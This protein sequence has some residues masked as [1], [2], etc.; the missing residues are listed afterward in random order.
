MPNANQTLGLYTFGTGTGW[1]G[2][3][4]LTEWPRVLLLW[5]VVGPVVTRALGYLPS[6]RLGLG[7]DL[8]VG[9]YRQWRRWCGNRNHWFGDPGSNFGERFAGVHA[10]QVLAVNSLDDRWA[11]PPSAAAFLAGYSGAEVTLRSVAPVDLG[12]PAI[13]HLGYFRTG[14]AEP[15]WQHLLEWLGRAGTLPRRR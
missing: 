15:L 2:H 3:M 5:H 6:S 8:P 1:H 4:P 13:G 11:P 12:V 14:V 9:V 7:E 10:P